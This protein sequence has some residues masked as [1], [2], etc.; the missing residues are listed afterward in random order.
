MENSNILE[1][2][3]IL[4]L[5]LLM[6][7]CS[8]PPDTPMH[9]AARDGDVEEL[10]RLIAAGED[11]RQQ[12]Q[13]NEEPIHHTTHYARYETLQALL[14]AGAD[15]EAKEQHDWTALHLMATYS[16]IMAEAA[17]QP[18]GASSDPCDAGQALKAQ[19]KMLEILI[20]AGA[21]LTALDEEFRT[22]LEL[23]AE[24]GRDCTVGFLR[25]AMSSGG[26]QGMQRRGDAAHPVQLTIPLQC[27]VFKTDS[28]I[29]R[30][31]AETFPERFK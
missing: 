30:I 13:G 5:Y 21:D 7:F 15:I 1:T 31:C 4:F 9:A 3:P 18:C 14:D 24:Y 26:A 19:Q 16:P 29:G 25:Q 27:C 12:T 22:P 28:P 23:A 20:A 10:R 6:A 17:E 8:L 2:I 11:V